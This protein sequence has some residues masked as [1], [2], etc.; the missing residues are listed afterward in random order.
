MRSPGRPGR[1]R[2]LGPRAGRA[3]GQRDLA[4]PRRPHFD[5]L[6]R[7][8]PHTHASRPRARRR[9]ARG[10]DGQQ[11]GRPPQLRRR[12]HRRAGHRRASTSP[13]PTAR[14]ARTRRC[15]PPAS[16]RPAGA[17]ASTSSAS[18]PTAACTRSLEHLFALDRR[19]RHGRASRRSSSTP[20][21]TAATRRR[22][23]G[24][25]L[26]RRARALAARQTGVIGTVSGRYYAMDR[27]KRWD[28]VEHGLRRDRPRRGRRAPPTAAEARRAPPTRAARPTSSSSRRCIGDYDGGDPPTARSVLLSS[29]SGPTAMREL[30]AALA[31]ARSSTAFDRAGDPPRRHRTRP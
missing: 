12:P 23:S 1:P 10:A 7:D 26:P 27:D 5:G 24:R 11:R 13:S 16:R 14:F 29:T 15:S 3:A 31:D 4:R 8:Y 30:T 25:R 21:S 9:P 17:A 22:T 20:S 19:W 28:R 18:S 6:W 2:R